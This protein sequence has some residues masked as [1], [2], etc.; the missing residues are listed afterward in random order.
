[1]DK[2][3]DGSY[4]AAASEAAKEPHSEKAI[5]I[6]SL[7]HQP[8]ELE[9]AGLVAPTEEE[10]NTLRHVPDKIDWTAYSERF[11]R[12]SPSVIATECL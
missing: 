12:I 4:Y 9:L 5:S 6:N 8:D 11:I 2:Q 3:A 10:L 7:P 1:M